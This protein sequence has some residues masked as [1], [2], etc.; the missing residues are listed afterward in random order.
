M[1]KVTR[2]QAFTKATIYCDPEDE[3]WKI[4]EVGKED[5]QTFQLIEDVLAHWRDV[6]GVSIT[7]KKDA[8]YTPRAGE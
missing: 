2:S 1:A 8:D 7:I 5:T 3:V 4:E 6:E